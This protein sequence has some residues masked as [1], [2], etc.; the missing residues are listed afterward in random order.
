[1]RKDIIALGIVIFLFLALAFSARGYTIQQYDNGV[2]IFESYTIQQYD[3]G[4]LQFQ[5]NITDTCTCPGLNQNWEI[6]LEDTCVITSNCNLG[7]GDITFINEGNITFN[8]QIIA[9]QIGGLPDNQT[10][11]LGSNAEVLIG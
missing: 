11:Y 1:M 6:N 7:T 2:L 9:E 3:S 4:I 8:A 10:G 5:A